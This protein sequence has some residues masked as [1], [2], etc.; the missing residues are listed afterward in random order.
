MCVYVYFIYIYIYIYYL[1]TE[2][3]TS[4]LKHAVV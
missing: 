4:W 3:R 1:M 2:G